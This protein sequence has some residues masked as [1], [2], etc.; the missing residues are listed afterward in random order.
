M[1]TFSTCG[2]GIYIRVFSMETVHAPPPV[3]PRTKFLGLRPRY[4]YIYFFF[5]SD[6]EK[7]SSADFFSD[8]QVYK[9]FFFCFFFPIVLDKAE[10]SLDT[11]K[12]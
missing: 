8:P 7:L 12:I 6:V 9:L 1:G 2:T 11:K 10:H 5:C 4:I 3:T